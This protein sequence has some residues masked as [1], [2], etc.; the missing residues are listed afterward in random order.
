MCH[1][2]TLRI[3]GGHVSKQ[4]FCSCV[5]SVLLFDYDRHYWK[6]NGVLLKEWCQTSEGRLAAIIV[7]DQ[8]SRNVYRGTP[9]S[10]SFDNA[11][12]KLVLDGIALG[13]VYMY[14]LKSFQ[15]L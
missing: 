1:F 3:E 7:G 4:L 5:H 11:M 6:V 15:T 8:F 10:F 13:T 14:I 12:Y 2:A 9:K